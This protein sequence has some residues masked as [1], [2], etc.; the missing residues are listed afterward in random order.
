MIAK[1]VQSVRGRRGLWPAE[2]KQALLQERRAG[3]PLETMEETG[4][5]VPE[6]IEPYS[7]QA[8]H[9]ALGMR[10]PAESYAD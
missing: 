6:W 9:S 3:V 1:P 2:Q 7:H 10:A 5:Q 8:P 4:R